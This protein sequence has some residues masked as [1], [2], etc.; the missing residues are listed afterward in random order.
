MYNMLLKMYCSSFSAVAT[1]IFNW[2]MLKLLETRTNPLMGQGLLSSAICKNE[3]KIL[4]VEC[5]S[6]QCKV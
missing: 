6:T 4:K 3:K 2:S 5:G 1:C